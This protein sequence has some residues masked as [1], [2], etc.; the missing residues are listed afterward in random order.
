MTAAATPSDVDTTLRAQLPSAAATLV[1]A[2]P[3]A[4]LLWLSGAVPLHLA[5]C[6]D[7]A[8]SCSSCNRRGPCCCAQ[9]TPATWAR[10]QPGCSASSRP[11]WRSMRLL[12]RFSSWRAPRSRSGQRW[13]SLSGFVFHRRAGAGRPMRANELVALLVCGVATVLWC[14]GIAAA[15]EALAHHHMLTGWIDYFIHGGVISHFGDPL[16]RQQQ[17]ID[18]V[19]FAALVLSQRVVPPAGGLRRAARSSGAAACDVGVASARILHHVRGGL[20]AGRG[21]RRTGGRSGGGRRLDACAR[22]VELW[23]A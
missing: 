21:A 14:R 12:H 9:R 23:T 1:V 11:P 13:S 10:W 16:A 15:P 7:G 5:A 19:G 18:L 22:C 6:G 3:L 20:R 8:V 4:W 17:S 2:L